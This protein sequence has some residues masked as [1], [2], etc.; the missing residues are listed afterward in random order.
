MN[1]ID[2]IIL[3]IALSMDACTIAFIKGNN[4]NNISYLFKI[5]ITFGIFQAIMPLI[6]YTLSNL[7]TKSILGINKILS[8]IILIYI[9]INMINE[10]I[11]DEDNNKNLIIL[12]IATSIDAL[13]SGI[14][15]IHSKIYI[16]YSIFIIGLI[17]FILSTL[18]AFIGYI[19]GKKINLKINL[20]GG[21]TLILL[22]I[23]IFTI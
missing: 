16:L 13:A 4:R 9:G 3:G 5:G 6:G 20:I 10:K 2:I 21:I 8:S 18:F 7:I 11:N 1:I 15:L 19:V 12:A 22:G 17:T 14:T 23:K